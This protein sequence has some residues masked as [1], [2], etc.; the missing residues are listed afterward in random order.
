MNIYWLV[1]QSYNRKTR[2][3]TVLAS[4]LNKNPIIKDVTVC[5]VDDN[6]RSYRLYGLCIG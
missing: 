6:S 2:E 3:V 1:Q 4:I 5:G